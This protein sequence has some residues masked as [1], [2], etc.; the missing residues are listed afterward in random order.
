MNRSQGTDT[1]NPS[2]ELEA[3]FNTRSAAGVAAALQTGDR[4]IMA[5]TMQLLAAR[6]GGQN[7]GRNIQTT[8]YERRDLTPIKKEDAKKKKKPD[9][10][11]GIINMH[12]SK[13]HKPSPH[14]LRR[15][16]ITG[17]G[18]R[19][20]NSPAE[21]WWNQQSQELIDFLYEDQ[22]APFTAPF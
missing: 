7:F 10:S 17:G 18:F 19:S 4:V 9:I 1:S 12:V 6:T 21:A 20:H 2:G 14:V 11:R 22:T 13:V 15:A 8:S 5:K 3:L 16:G